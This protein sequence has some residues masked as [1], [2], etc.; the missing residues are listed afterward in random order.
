MKTNRR[1]DI[2]IKKNDSVKWS[3]NRKDENSWKTLVEMKTRLGDGTLD[4]LTNP[5]FQN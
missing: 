5:N 1:K 3:L 2:R 4:R